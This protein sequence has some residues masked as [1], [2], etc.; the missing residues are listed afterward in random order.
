M[1]CLSLILL[2]AWWI[3]FWFV[4]SSHSVFVL[5]LKFLPF[6]LFH[7]FCILFL[8]I[9]IF[10][11][12]LSLC[13][14]YS[15]ILSHHF[16]FHVIVFY[17][18]EE[19]KISFSIK[20]FIFLCDYWPIMTKANMILSIMSMVFGQ[21]FLTLAS[22][23]FIFPIF[24]FAIVFKRS[25]TENMGYILKIIFNFLSYICSYIHIYTIHPC[26]QCSAIFNFF[27]TESI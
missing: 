27:F 25:I 19:L 22:N 17:F 15:S 20:G 7:L 1:G 9:T 6:F 18:L 5:L 21:Y 26:L 24:Q 3:L 23:H 2:E 10:W 4:N 12:H 16:I 8:R 11:L 13:S 14:L